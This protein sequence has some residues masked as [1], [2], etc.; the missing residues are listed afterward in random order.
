MSV[1]LSW[2][3]GV[4]VS[5]LHVA[6]TMAAGGSL[7]DPVLEESLALPVQDLLA[8]VEPAGGRKAKLLQHLSALSGGIQNNQELAELALVKTFGRDKFKPEYARELAYKIGDL[9]QAMLKA[10]PK[11]LDELT[12]RGEP[13][14][15]QW[16]ARGPGVWRQ[17][18]LK[19]EP[20]LLVESAK[21][22]LVLPA[23]GGGGA[24]HWDYNSVRI[25]AVLANPMAELP[26]VLRL[27]WLLSQLQLDLPMYR[28]L[29]PADKWETVVSLAMI[30][31]V[32]L[33]GE[34]VELTQ[35]NTST[36][37][38]AIENWT[39]ISPEI[40]SEQ[41]SALETWWP[42]YHASRPRF[43]V[44]LAALAEMV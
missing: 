5:G 9:E 19:T 4:S 35:F 8:T 26:E 22:F 32:L 42:T 44:A 43:A 24:A 18:G 40:A 41:A 13:L 38:L 29:I 16:E 2:V 33:G 14:R 3:A 28:E 15:Q 25:E 21:V 7:V 11:L 34:E 6:S 12:M 1:N 31:P 39:Q 27:A 37:A 36:L 20:D 30:P 10:K 17:I 23:S